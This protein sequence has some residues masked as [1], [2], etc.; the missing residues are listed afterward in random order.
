MTASIFISGSSARYFPFLRDLVT[1][2]EPARR[3]LG[4]ALGVLDFGMPDDALAWLAGRGAEIVRIRSILAQLPEA[5]Q[6]TEFLPYVTRPR[7]ADLFPA[8]ERIL[9]FDA[10]TWFQTD[11]ALDP[12][13]E[14][15][16]GLTIVAEVHRSYRFQ[17]WLQA[18]MIKH[19]VTG[20]GPAR[21]LWL[22]SKPH[23]NAG[24][25]A[26]PRD[27][28]HWPR[29]KALYDRAFARTGRALPHDQFA[30]IQTAYQF[31]RERHILPAMWNWIADRGPPIWDDT[32]HVFCTPLREPIRVMA[33]AGPA[34]TAT[35]R[36]P[37]VGG[38][39]VETRLNFEAYARLR[40][41]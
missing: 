9:W 4:V 29:W 15:R 28:P 17:A 21:G 11:D 2:S 37:R 27:A 20:Y 41:T 26:L 10:D 25:F 1:S 5:Q 35:Y 36:V 16:S 31:E 12:F 7:L 3:R 40:G 13:V 23:L 38:G 30:L 24:A 39:F 6:R 8:Y 19:F 34:K 32:A 33:L 18:W 14:P 22:H